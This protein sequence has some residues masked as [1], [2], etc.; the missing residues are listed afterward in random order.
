M[1]SATPA[2][3]QILAVLLLMA[4]APTPWA[5]E[6]QEVRTGEPGTFS[7]GVGGE[8]SRGDYG[9]STTTE[10]W[11]LPFSMAYETER[12]Y[13]GVKLPYLY[14]EGAGNV[15]I[16]G[17]QPM[18]SHTTSTA[19]GMGGMASTTGTS[20]ASESGLGDVVGTVSYRL[21]TETRDRPYFDLTGKVYLGTADPDSGLG[22]GEN[23]YSLQADLG[24]EIGEVE[25]YGSVGYGL[26]GDP[27]GVSYRNV[28]FG[29]VGV[30]RDFDL[31]TA[32]VVLDMAQSIV[33]GND[34]LVSVRGYLT[35]WLDKKKEHKISTF[36]ELGLTDSVADIGVGVAYRRYY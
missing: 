23:S 12:W 21:L 24:R 35:K 33:S 28:L 1:R 32:G 17:G 30:E 18:G 16:M 5:A 8:Y 29:H 27:P 13:F 26:I 2:L 19:S 36:L 25:V 14:V 10:I 6:P 4:A 20:T 15:V 34:P 3:L 7:L 11:Y 9:G 31:R 22:T